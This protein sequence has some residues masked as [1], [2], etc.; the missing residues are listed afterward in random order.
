MARTIEF[1]NWRISQFFFVFPKLEESSFY[2]I[3]CSISLWQICWSFG[4]VFFFINHLSTGIRHEDLKILIHPKI[5]INLFPTPPKKMISLPFLG[6]GIHHDGAVFG[7]V[8]G[9]LCW[10]PMR[11]PTHQALSN[12][13][14]HYLLDPPVSDLLA[15]GTLMVDCLK[16]WGSVWT[17]ICDFHLVGGRHP[18]SRP[19]GAKKVAKLTSVWGANTIC[20]KHPCLGWRP[21]LIGNKN[22]PY[23][24][25]NSQYCRTYVLGIFPSTGLCLVAVDYHHSLKSECSLN[26]AKNQ[27][28]T[29]ILIFKKPN[30]QTCQILPVPVASC[31]RYTE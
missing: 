6:A 15:P 8:S 24:C 1:G 2:S 13:N 11:L 27:K 19:M 9:D 21:V 20:Y 28:D 18:N 23:S 16:L 25:Q 31:A 22:S 4:D 29:Y 12:L 26:A 5:F 10:K 7:L 14:L 17:N 3:T 30:S